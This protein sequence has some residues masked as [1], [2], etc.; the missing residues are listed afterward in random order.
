MAR[1]AE[2]LAAECV[3]VGRAEGAQLDDG[4]A[5]AAVGRLAAGPPGSGSSILT[6]RLAGRRLEWEARN[7]VVQRLG[8]RHG[9]PTPVTDVI[10]PLLAVC[11]LPAA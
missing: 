5:A 2:R 7:G 10:V 6:D 8:A 4:I 9:I 3:A 1:L 11:G